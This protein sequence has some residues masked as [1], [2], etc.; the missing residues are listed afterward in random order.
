M[1]HTD[2][3]TFH[4][5]P[6]R[7]RWLTAAAAVTAALAVASTAAAAPGTQASTQQ[8]ADVDVAVASYAS[9]YGVSHQEAQRRLDRIYP[10][11]DILASIRS[12]ETARLAG[13]G[14]DHSG[15]FM[16][17][18]WLTGTQSPSAN[19][20]S[21]ANAHADV[22]IRTGAANS[23]A[24]LLNAQD[25]LI[26]IGLTGRV[27]DS[28]GYDVWDIVTFTDIDMRTNSIKTGIDPALGMS[29]P[30]G[31]NNTDKPPVTDEDFQ[32]KAAEVADIL[33]D[34]VPVGF[35]VVDGRGV[36]PAETFAGGEQMG[37][38]TAGFAAQETGGGRYGMITAG[39]CG[40]DGPN[41]DTTFDMKG[42]TLPFVYGWASVTADAQ[43]HRIP[44]GSSHV[45][46]DDY[47]CNYRTNTRCDV[48]GSKARR[49]MVKRYR[50]RI[51][52]DYVCH[53]GRKTGVSCGTVASINYQPNY[54]GACIDASDNET[55]CDNVFVKV[56]GSTLKSCGGDSGGPWY[57]LGVAYGIHMASAPADNCDDPVSFAIFSAIREVESFLGV[58]ILTEGSVTVN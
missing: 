51:V 57:R 29:V 55:D 15:I 48:S 30:G 40:Y 44:T 39:H 46:H 38:C 33:R 42:V 3:T 22:E 43:F 8:P 12:L 10:L 24:A 1:R 19:A 41:E 2:T 5:R 7:L 9:E 31:I 16:G 50:N 47:I 25:G 23:Y 28:R 37:T 35:A 54:D 34:H 32:T 49:N 45:L 53:S 36:V 14:I 58:E 17:W 18:V 13:W 56:K 11:Q 52:G 21:I 27:K 6:R 4:Q 20:A 26:Q